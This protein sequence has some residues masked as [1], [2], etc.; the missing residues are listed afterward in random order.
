MYLCHHGMAFSQ[1]TDADM[2]GGFEY[3]EQ[4]VSDSWRGVVLQLGIWARWLLTLKVTMLQ[5]TSQSLIYI[6][7]KMDLEEVG[8]GWRWLD[9]S[10]LG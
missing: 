6:S 1:V 7:I 3:I 10:G 2:G 8:R 4:T 9:L 5:T